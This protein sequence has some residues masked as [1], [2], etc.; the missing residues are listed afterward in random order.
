MYTELIAKTTILIER[1]NQSLIR[2]EDVKKNTDYE[3]DF[4]NEVKP[5]VDEVMEIADRW[6]QLANDWIEKEKPK[7]LHPNQI[8]AT[9]ENIQL[10]SIQGFYKDTKARRFKAMYESIMYVLESI[11]KKVSR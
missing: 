7:H 1:C 8:D 9:H 2:M 11:N 5:Y 6:M 3:A 10:I 4:Y